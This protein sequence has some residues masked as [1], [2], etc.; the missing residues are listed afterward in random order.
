MKLLRGLALLPM[1]P[2]IWLQLGFKLDG[3]C[4]P[5]ECGLCSDGGCCERAEKMVRWFRGDV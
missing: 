2:L 4:E 3:K 1:W 5:N